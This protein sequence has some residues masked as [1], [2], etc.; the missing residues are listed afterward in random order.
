MCF[1]DRFQMGRASLS[2][3]IAILS[4]TGI[5][6]VF[7]TTSIISY[8]SVGYGLYAQT[9]NSTYPHPQKEVTKSGRPIT[10]PKR[11][12]SRSPLNRLWHE[13]CD[14][15]RPLLEPQVLDIMVVRFRNENVG[16]NSPIPIVIY[17]NVLAIVGF[18]EVR[19]NDSTSP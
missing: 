18:E 17:C 12:I 5:R 1:Y 13:L 6:N 4:C 11:Q 7:F 10:G 19:T 3:C 2:K 9:N 8:D 15:L 16:N 14:I